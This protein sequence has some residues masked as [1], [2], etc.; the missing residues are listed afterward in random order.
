MPGE[1]QKKSHVVGPPPAQ[2]PVY[3]MLLI[4]VKLGPPVFQVGYNYNSYGYP[5]YQLSIAMESSSGR[6]QLPPLQ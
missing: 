4:K 5:S 2:R 1:K 3:F 6:L